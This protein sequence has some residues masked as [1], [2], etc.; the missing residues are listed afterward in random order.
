MDIQ[1]G[2]SRDLQVKK[3]L[4][5]LR[6]K[7]WVSLRQFGYI[8]GISYPT[9]LKYKEQGK[10]WYVQVGHT[11]RVPGDEVVRFLTHGTEDVKPEVGEIDLTPVRGA[12]E[13][14]KRIMAD[15]AK[16]GLDSESHD[17]DDSTYGEEP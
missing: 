17:S 4:H 1:S 3:A 10:F 5:H 13:L 12:A 8:V 7:G 9:V 11:G 6:A 14:V 15:R 2:G 16:E